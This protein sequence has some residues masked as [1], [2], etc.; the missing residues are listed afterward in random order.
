MENEIM[1][2]LKMPL[3]FLVMM[4]SWAVVAPVQAK[5][6]KPNVLVIFGDDIG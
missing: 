4:A 1:K 2:A 6:S 5:E 3:L